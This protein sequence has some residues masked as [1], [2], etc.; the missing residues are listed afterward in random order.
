MI[1]LI[2]DHSRE[3]SR[4]L[5]VNVQ[6]AKCFKLLPQTNPTH[7]RIDVRK[8][9]RLGMQYRFMIIPM[10]FEIMGATG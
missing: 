1:S 10:A 6:K 3:F 5:N 2:S 4:N 9:S 8:I 7:A